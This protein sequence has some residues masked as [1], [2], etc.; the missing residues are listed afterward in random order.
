[1]HTQHGERTARSLHTQICTPLV[2]DR[3]AED[4]ARPDVAM[5]GV[6]GGRLEKAYLDGRVFNPCPI[7]LWKLT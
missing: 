5:H 4:V 1:M 7:E 3:N 2:V 6:W